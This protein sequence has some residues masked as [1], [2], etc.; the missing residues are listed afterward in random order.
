LPSSEFCRTILCWHG[1]IIVRFVFTISLSLEEEVHV[2]DLPPGYVRDVIAIA[3]TPF[4][5]SFCVAVREVFDIMCVKM[6]HF[7]LWK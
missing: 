2:D 4:R 6:V 3:S 7:V 5:D 1:A